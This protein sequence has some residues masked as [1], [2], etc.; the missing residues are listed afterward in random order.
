MTGMVPFRRVLGTYPKHKLTAPLR[1]ILGTI[2][3][4]RGL[5]IAICLDMDIGMAET[6]RVHKRVPRKTPINW[7]PQVSWG[8]DGRRVSDTVCT[9][10][11]DQQGSM[12]I[13]DHLRSEQCIG[14]NQALGSSYQPGNI[15]ANI[16]TKEPTLSDV[17]TAVQ[18]CNNTLFSLT[19]Q[20]LELKGDIAVIRQENQ[21][22][23]ERTTVLENRVGVMEDALPFI[24]KELQQT[25]A[26]IRA[27]A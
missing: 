11:P 5:R 14:G 25:K 1:K 6:S 18:A 21:K 4:S 24:K 2:W 26:Q 22:I 20:M 7:V 19:S 12:E 3:L 9:P 27:Q 8:L 16:S 15:V 10:N 17:F 13:Q 23:C